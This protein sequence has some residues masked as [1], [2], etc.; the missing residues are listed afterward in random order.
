MYSSALP[1]ALSLVCIEYRHLLEPIQ[2]FGRINR[3]LLSAPHSIA[4]CGIFGSQTLSIPSTS[5][6]STSHPAC[7]GP[8][9]VVNSCVHSSR[10][11][12]T[13]LVKIASFLSIGILSSS[14]H[15][16]PCRPLR[17]GR[18]I[19]QMTTRA[20][21]GEKSFEEHSEHLPSQKQRLV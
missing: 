8:Y 6:A 20:T 21:T 17:L 4:D 10:S 13:S 16:S 11:D 1:K 9:L 19:G 5:S 18:K 15:I 14:T 3:S 12:E 2:R 7:P